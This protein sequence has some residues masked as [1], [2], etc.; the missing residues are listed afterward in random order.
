MQNL[1]TRILAGLFLAGAISCARADIA[2]ETETGDL[3]KKGEGNFSQ[4]IQYDKY[5][6]GRTTFLLTQFEYAMT[7][8]SE[9]LIEPFFYQWTRE[10]GGVRYEG[11]GDLEITPSYRFWRE[12]SN[13]PALLAAFKVKVPMASNRD[14]GTGK[15]DYYPYFIINKHFGEWDVNVNLGVEFFGQYG[16]EYL[17]PQLIYDVSVQ[18]PIT[19][20]LEGIVEIFGNSKPTA[21]E[22]ATFAG[23][24]ALEYEFSKHF[25]VFFSVGF[26]TDSTWSFRP[27]FNIPF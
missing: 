26:D 19:K 24:V 17:R 14:I 8:D 1:D 15:V 27:G 2:L 3:G 25:N 23:A 21:S 9:L 12:T 13:S 10:H 18:H 11:I 16:H 6:G 5:P 22:K 4:G 20:H 7:D